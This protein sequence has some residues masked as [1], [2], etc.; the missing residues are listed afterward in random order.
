LHILN[1]VALGALAVLVIAWLA[2]SFLSPGAR[3]RPLEWIAATAMY[4][5]LLAFFSRQLLDAVA[6]DSLVRMFAFGFLV[7]VFGLGL[8]ISTWRTVAALA[9]RA[10]SAGTG[11]TH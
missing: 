3:R 10:G 5:A 9:G 6:D 11:A 7:T 8:V 1:V 4:V 2:V